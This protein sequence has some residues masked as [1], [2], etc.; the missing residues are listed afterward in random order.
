M[1]CRNQEFPPNDERYMHPQKRQ[2]R[3]NFILQLVVTVGY[4]G[5]SFLVIEHVTFYHNTYIVILV[6]KSGGQ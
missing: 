1:I 5:I 2:I 4:L 3:Q 6:Y